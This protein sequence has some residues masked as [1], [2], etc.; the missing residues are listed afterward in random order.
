MAGLGAPRPWSQVLDFMHGLDGM[1][2]GTLHPDVLSDNMMFLA[3]L[4]PEVNKLIEV[5]SS[6]L[7]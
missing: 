4:G 6:L 1:D 5:R 2:E 3:I 7:V